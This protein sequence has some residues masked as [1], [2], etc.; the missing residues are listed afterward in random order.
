MENFFKRPWIIVA[1]IAVI[2]IFFA[3]QLPRVVLDNN[4]FRFVP[5]SDPARQVSVYIDNTFGSS[6]FI[7]VGLEKKYGTVLDRDFLLRL[8]EYIERIRE[9][10]VVGSI[11]SIVNADYITGDGE[12][13]IV[14]KLV[15][16]DFS[17]TAEEIA[18]LKR[19]L[20]SWN[21][22]ERALISDDFTATQV[23]VPL[24]VSQDEVGSPEIV[25]KLLKIRDTAREMFAGYAEVYV[26]GFPIVSG[27]ISEA[28]FADLRLLI[29]L[30]IIIVLL[31][32]WL[33]LR[34]IGMVFLSL[35]GVII[36]AIWSIG[37]MPLLGVKLSVI[38]TVMPVI[39]I[40]V[41]NSY[42]LHVIIHYMEGSGKDF[43]LMSR[44]EHSLF[45]VGMLRKVLTPIFLAALTTFVSF[46]SFCF[47]TVIPIREFGAFSSFGVLCSFMIAIVLVPAILIIRGP[48]PLKNRK[49]AK[50]ENRQTDESGGD[51]A[52][53]GLARA[54]C[55][56]VAKKRTVITLTAIIGIVSIFGAAR[57]VTDNVFTEY[58]R[59]D[60]DIVKSDQFIRAK[61]GGSKVLSVV[62]QSDSTETLLH[63]DTLTAMDNLNTYLIE[64]VAETGKVMG[65]TDLVKR[66][67]Q[68]FNI[69][70]N[71]Q[72]LRSRPG[73]QST[74]IDTGSAGFGFAEPEDSF[75]FSDA[76]DS[77]GFGGFAEET[78]PNST[79][80]TAVSLL[81]DAPL[82][83]L[84]LLAL[85]DSAASSHRQMNASDLVASLKK[86]VNYEGAA[87][88]EIPA[89]P[90]RYGKQ[91]PE[92]LQA[93]VS[94]YLVLL[95]G[96][97]SE[98]ANDPLEP[99]AI[100]TTIQLAT[101][102]QEDTDHTI[103]EISRYVDENFPKNV[104]VIIGGGAVVE[105]SVN[106]RIVGSLWTSIAIAVLSLFIII[107]IVNRSFIAGLVSVVP[108]GLLILV[109]FAIMGFTG[110]KLNVGTALISSLTLGIGIDYIIHFLEAYKSAY[111]ESG[112]KGDFLKSAYRTSGLA[113][114][115]DA[116]STGAG[117]VVLIF[118]NFVMLAQFGLLTAL[119]LL[120][121]GIVGLLVVPALLL[122]IK[123]KFLAKYIKHP[124]F[125]DER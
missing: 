33:P 25:A 57:L 29:P 40:A 24:S 107:T 54:M 12:A 98:Y 50:P 36:A 49:K 105:G 58:F 9:I 80:D 91:T 93:L 78:I 104:E 116:V 43:A 13:I 2:T 117:F 35:L 61:F 59:A 62:V 42:G 17:G 101:S 28:V 75:G 27:T 53:D 52:N 26:A 20:L 10:D 11:N 124:H 70:E 118:S 96:N 5:E 23:Y 95:A 85:L 64:R 90:A 123:P 44:E 37:A 63:P 46:V 87:Y 73:L 71:P 18:E 32:I 72:G 51:N 103:A 38:T 6:Q 102:G 122:L 106:D 22:Y 48:V 119:S 4:N 66:I 86:K 92:E 121:S 111:R 81:P 3:A 74:A 7:L 97:I 99:T 31:I 68:V 125:A 60:T 65:F 39:L 84:E 69:G 100:K 89:D 15:A 113:V 88:Y 83:T 94:N 34:R 19:R 21:M 14:E 41:G 47:T 82:P 67:N 110:I 1:V 30:V 108:L 8:G 45:I 112:G 115:T 76:G 56:I 55:A 77:F 109:N 79:A 114:I 16:D 120:L